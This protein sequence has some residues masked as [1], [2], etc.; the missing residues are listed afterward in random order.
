MVAAE[1]VVAAEEVAGWAP[2]KAWMTDIVII[3]R[4]VTAAALHREIS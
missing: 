4:I 3:T 2:G 1:Q